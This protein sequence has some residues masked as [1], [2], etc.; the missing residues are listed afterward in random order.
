MDETY[1]IVHK[2]MGEVAELLCSHDPKYLVGADGYV[3]CTNC[4]QTI[5]WPQ[6]KADCSHYVQDDDGYCD[7]CGAFVEPVDFI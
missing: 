2:K 5:G 4:Y 1:Q 3:N 6:D 7:D